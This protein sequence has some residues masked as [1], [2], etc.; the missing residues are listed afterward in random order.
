MGYRRIERKKPIRRVLQDTTTRNRTY[1]QNGATANLA[2]P[3]WY[4]VVDFP[5]HIRHHHIDYHDHIGWPDP[6][7]PDESCQDS[8]LDNMI[9]SNRYSDKHH[10]W[11]GHR[12]FLN[13]SKFF[14]IHL[15]D[16]GYTTV[17]IAFVNP[18]T[19]LTAHGYIDDYVVRF[20]LEPRCNA[21]IE[22]DVDVPYTV[23]INGTVGNRKARD[24]VAKG[25]LHILSGAID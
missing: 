16:E 20:T 18:P 22:E 5:Q 2:V 17:D 11:F 15:E 6:T 9:P 4:D 24:V 25:I 1:V 7:H 19:G 10:G 12:R 8:H 3:C 13:M 23:F 21:A 14:P